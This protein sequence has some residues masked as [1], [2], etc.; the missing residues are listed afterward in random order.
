VRTLDTTSTQS[1]LRRDLWLLFRMAAML[2]QYGTTGARQRRAYRRC[3][4]RGE[5]YYVD[6]AGQTRHREEALRR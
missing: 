6:G 2:I 4:E 1:A 3:V 5:V